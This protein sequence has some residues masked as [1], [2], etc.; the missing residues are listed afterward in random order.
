MSGVG[1][2]NEAAEIGRIVVTI[3]ATGDDAKGST[4]VARRNPELKVECSN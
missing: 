4:A 3:G 1:H 2:G